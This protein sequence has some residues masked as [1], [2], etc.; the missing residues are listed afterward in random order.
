MHVGGGELV[1][2]LVVHPDSIPFNLW[3]LW[4]KEMTQVT[5]YLLISEIHL[6]M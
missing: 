1:L 5:L 6:S 4:N 2:N 3:K